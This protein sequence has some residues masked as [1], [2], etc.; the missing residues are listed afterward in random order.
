MGNGHFPTQNEEANAKYA[1][2]SQISNLAPA[3]IHIF[4]LLI[5]EGSAAGGAGASVGGAPCHEESA[6]LSRVEESA[7]LMKATSG[8]G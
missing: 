1:H 3:D 4:L 7:G 6:A 2:H 8:L 5:R